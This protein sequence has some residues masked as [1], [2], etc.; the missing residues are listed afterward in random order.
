M[1]KMR[2]HLA[3]KI[4]AAICHLP[5][6]QESGQKYDIE[7]SP[8][9]NQLKCVVR[10]DKQIAVFYKPD[11]QTKLRAF[12]VTKSTLLRIL[13]DARHKTN[14]ADPNLNYL[15]KSTLKLGFFT[16]EATK[17]TLKKILKMLEWYEQQ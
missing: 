7:G 5:E 13:K 9:M 8:K 4:K 3:H 1:P 2:L 16:I 11:Q 15:S 17:T 6:L 12:V 14:L 10:P